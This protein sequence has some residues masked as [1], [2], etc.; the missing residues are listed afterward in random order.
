M[1][2]VGYILL[3]VVAKGSLFDNDTMGVGMIQLPADVDCSKAAQVMLDKQIA[4]E[5]HCIPL[6]SAK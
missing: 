4:S 2:L 6:Y 1:T 3:T 5:A